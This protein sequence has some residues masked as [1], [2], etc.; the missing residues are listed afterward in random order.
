MFTL[1]PVSAWNYALSKNLTPAD[2]RIVRRDTPGYPWDV[3]NSP[4]SLEVGT[5]R[6][7]KNWRLAEC[8]VATD[9]PERPEIDGNATTLHL[10]PLG[11][12]LLRVSVFAKG[13]N[14]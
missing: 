1:Y 12:T 11:G 3:G 14:D 5:A 2:I 13:P 6:R 10:E 9:I 7:V 8:L 4:I